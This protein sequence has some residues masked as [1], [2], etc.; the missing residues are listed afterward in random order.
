MS[1]NKIHI[2]IALYTP[3]IYIEAESKNLVN[4]Y[5]E[6]NLLEDYKSLFSENIL[7]NTDIN[8]VNVT[9]NEIIAK[10]LDLIRNNN[11][12]F[13]ALTEI[14]FYSKV[15][16]ENNTFKY[17]EIKT[18][19]YNDKITEYPNVEVVFS[20]YC[21][22]GS[23]EKNQKDSLEI[24]VIPNEQIIKETTKIKTTTSNKY[25]GNHVVL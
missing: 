5:N 6:S 14:K 16:G 20:N 13:S 15:K 23:L 2:F 25:I 8:S 1:Y 18:T 24:P 7:K 22:N 19:E 21:Y 10:F 11:E 12:K 9:F 3:I 17:Y 4:Y